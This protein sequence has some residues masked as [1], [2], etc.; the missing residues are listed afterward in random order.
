M[1]EFMISENAFIIS[2][3][4]LI[5]SVENVENEKAFIVTEMLVSLSL[6]WAARNRQLN[7]LDQK[8]FYS[9][10]NDLDFIDTNL[11]SLPMNI[12]TLAMNK[13]VFLKQRK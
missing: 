7:K 5:A 1:N 3:S 6:S 11:L 10:V 4:H 9:T 13:E 2:V 8:L 12:I